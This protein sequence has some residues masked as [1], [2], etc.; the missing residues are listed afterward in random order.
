M[1]VLRGVTVQCV[2]YST[3]KWYH[4]IVAGMQQTDG[5]RKCNGC[6]SGGVT[7]DTTST[8]NQFNRL[9]AS[10][11]LSVRGLLVWE[12]DCLGLPQDCS[13]D[14][15]YIEI[16]Q[17]LKH[18]QTFVCLYKWKPFLMQTHTSMYI[19]TCM[20]THIHIECWKGKKKPWSWKIKAKCR[21]QLMRKMSVNRTLCWKVC[22]PNC[23]LSTLAQSSHCPR[24]AKTVTSKRR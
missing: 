22:H 23:N 2:I 15:D 9:R 24:P 20:Y 8:V 12:I 6:V 18:S 4:G 17:A 5:G 14:I 7:G 19:Q 10:L 21:R 3:L 11:L 1:L 16:N 13:D